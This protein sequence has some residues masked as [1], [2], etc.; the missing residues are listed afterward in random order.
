MGTGAGHKG[1]TQRPLL[2]LWAI[3]A[4]VA[5]TGLVVFLPVVRESPI[6]VVVALGFVLFAPGY[7]LIAALF[8]EAGAR[9]ATD[10]ELGDGI[11]GLERA[12]LSF[13]ASIAIVPLVGLVLNFTPWGITLAPIII[14]L[15]SL[16]LALTA[17][18]GVRR[19]RL[20]PAERFTVSVPTFDGV[21]NEFLQPTDRTDAVLNVVLVLSL[22]VAASSLT[23]AIAAPP[24]GESFTEL[25]LLTETEDGNLTASNYPQNFTQ[26]EAKPLTVSITNQEGKQ[27]SY[28]LVAELQR[29]N[30]SEEGDIRVEEVNELDRFSPTLAANETWRQQH[31]V[32]PH[33]TGERLR[34]QYSLYR[35][36]APSNQSDDAYRSVQLWVN[37]ST[38]GAS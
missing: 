14:S 16:T 6:R 5:V 2:D 30:V 11:D 25:S 34:L 17:L 7:A 24:Q 19:L 22:L 27:V 3:V 26:G 28:T 1:G 20:A 36:E 29:V 32:E 9:V 12:V 13:G 18:A 10:E 31:L 21:R 33:L 38:A 4:L 37:V 23:F 8:P 35:G 15:G